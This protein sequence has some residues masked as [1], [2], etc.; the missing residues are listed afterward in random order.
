MRIIFCGYGRAALECFYQLTGN[1]NVKLSDIIVF[2]HDSPEN[3]EFVK[4]LEVNSIRITYDNINN[5]LDLIKE[6]C[7]NYLLSIYYRHIISIDILN[8]VNNKAMNLHP[9]LLPAYKGT[10]SSVWAIL[11][12]EKYTGV[13]FHYMDSSIDTGKIIL[14]KKITIKEEDTAYSLYH[15]LIGV[16][17]SNFCEAFDLLV[18]SYNG[19][20]QKGL[21]S[22]YSR[23]LPCE[24]EIKIKDLSLEDA[25]R[26]VRAM[27]FPPYKGAVFILKDESK[28]EVNSIKD[29]HKYMEFK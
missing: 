6:F 11:N 3:S 26:F 13:S 29:L 1:Y 28:V 20:E 22:Y 23:K 12:N 17:S 24:G 27:Y 7:P 14:Q 19:I 16:F 2:T 15:K 25:R 4:H 21:S 18:S 5:S 10:K 9:S 8:I